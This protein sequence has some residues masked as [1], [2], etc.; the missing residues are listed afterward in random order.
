MKELIKRL[1]KP[2]LFLSII[3]VPILYY[4][5]LDNLSNINKFIYSGIFAFVSVFYIILSRN[6]YRKKLIII[7][8]I[9]FVISIIYIGVF[10]NQVKVEKENGHLITESN[11][12][13]LLVDDSYY[14]IEGTVEGEIIRED[15]LESEIEIEE[16]MTNTMDEYLIEQGFEEYVPSYVDSKIEY[17]DYIFVYDNSIIYK[18]D[19]EGN[20]LDVSDNLKE[21]G[22]SAKFL[23]IYN[24][25]LYIYDK[26]EIKT[27]T[28][29]L[30]IRDVFKVDSKIAE[31]NSLINGIVKD[32][33]IYLL[34]TGEVL[35]YD[36]TGNIILQTNLGMIPFEGEV[37]ELQTYISI[38]DDKVYIH[39]IYSCYGCN[40]F[41]Q[42]TS[43]L[44]SIWIGQ[45]ISVYDFD[46]N[47]KKDITFGYVKPAEYFE[48]GYSTIWDPDTRIY[49]ENNIYYMKSSKYNAEVKELGYDIYYSTLHP[50]IFSDSFGI[51]DGSNINNKLHTN[52]TFRI[53]R[54]LFLPQLVIIM[55]ID[56]KNLMKIL[57]A[58]S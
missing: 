15:L 23:S 42:Y 48:G 11:N 30:E 12:M 54:L 21:N 52:F 55:I 1:I 49:E 46:L 29:D 6:H 10:L 19:K 16:K 35:K 24:D 27:I 5:N 36:L 39:G 28:T 20:M 2:I 8:I 34:F 53:I 32:G 31:K 57:K 50:G 7:S 33:Y 44:A 56:F 41:G 37:S 51:D 40:N 43:K 3:L 9:F 14:I 22:G 25:E 13:R 26:G 58:Q 17:G 47:Y 38:S 45:H 4:I 18:F